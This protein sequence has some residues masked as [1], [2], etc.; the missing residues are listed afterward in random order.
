MAIGVFWPSD[1]YKEHLQKA[2]PRRLVKPHHWQEKTFWGITLP[3]SHGN[4]SDYQIDGRLDRDS[5]SGARD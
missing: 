3:D 4:P 2:L 5:G 1:V